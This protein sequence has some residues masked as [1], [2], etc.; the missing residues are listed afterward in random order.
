MYARK[1]SMA[2]KKLQGTARIKALDGLRGTGWV[3]AKDRDAIS[4]SFQ[5][6]NFI[7]AMGFMTRA[8]IWSEKLN[9]HPEWF[10]VYSKVD[11]VLTTHDC[12]GLSDLDIKLAQKMDALSQ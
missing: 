3:E 4:K 10:N 1:V 8:A 12:G 5:F 11:V 2:K 7:E 6:S 9:H